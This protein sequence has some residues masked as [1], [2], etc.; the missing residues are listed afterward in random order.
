MT[1]FPTSLVLAAL[2]VSPAVADTALPVQIVT[3]RSEAVTEIYSVYGR[4]EATDSYR[5]AF[6]SGGRVTEVLADVGM[7]VHEG[8]VLARLDPTI[9]LAER[10]A[11]QASL[12][13][14]EAALQQAMQARDRAAQ[15]LERGVGTQAQLDAAT[16]AHLG[17]RA[18]RDQAQTRLE[19]ARQSVEDAELR[20]IEE[21]VVTERFVDP[22]E[23]T[24]AGTPVMTLAR[25]GQREAIFMAPDVAGLSA[26]MGRKV[27]LFPVE[28]TARYHGQVSEIVPVVAGSGT[29]TVTVSLNAGAEALPIGALVRAEF[30]ETQP[31]AIVL[32]WSSLASEPEGPAVWVVD[33]DTMTV[34]SRRVALAGYGDATVRI[35]AGIAEG[36]WVVAAG[37]HLL[38]PGRVVARAEDGQ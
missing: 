30:P 27:D 5:A 31:E 32:P 13:A 26:Q 36:D 12:Q 37:S 23:I 28:G 35:S 34:A 9:A 10:T 33:P 11:A 38:Y 18:T 2:C 6:R 7:L 17:A 8:E 22:G 29:V 24:G 20:A 25:A 16:E 14:A 1:R 4:I 21:A 19:K 3:A 15:L